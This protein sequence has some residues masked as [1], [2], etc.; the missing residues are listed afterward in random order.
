[1]TSEKKSVQDDDF[2]CP[3][4]FQCDHSMNGSPELYAKISKDGMKRGH[5]MCSLHGIEIGAS[6]VICDNATNKPPINKPQPKPVQL[7]SETG[8]EDF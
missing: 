2:R 4:C 5:R 6:S 3:K 8:W 7:K 1:M